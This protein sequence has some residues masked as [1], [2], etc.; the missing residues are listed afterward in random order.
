MNTQ[1]HFSIRFASLLINLF[2]APLNSSAVELVGYV[3]HYRLDSNYLNNILPNQL[4][5][6]DEVRYFGLSAGSNG[7]ITSLSGSIASHKNN[8]AAIKAIID[9]LPAADRPRLDITLGG[10]SQDATFTNVAA[11]S[12]LRTVLAE[13]IVSLLD[14]TGAMAVDIDWE[15]PNNGV[16]LDSSYPALLKRIKQEVGAER[17]VYATVAPSLVISNSIFTG[18]DAIDG[19]SLMTYDLGWW[20]NDPSDPNNGEHSLP[21]HTADALQAWTDSPGSTNQRPWVFG[22]WGNGS[23]SE[24]IGVGLPFYGRNLT[25]GSAFTYGQLESGGSTSDGN[26]YSYQGQTVWI[27]GPDLVEQRVQFADENN[28][29]NLIIWELA[30]DSNP[31]DP[32][33]LLRRAYEAKTALEDLPGDYDGDGSIDLDDYSVWSTTYGSTLDLRADGNADGI[34]DAA[35][36]TIWRDLNSVAVALSATSIPEPLSSSL[37]FLCLPFFVTA[38]TF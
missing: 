4:V 18:P 29:Q 27:P 38:R 28:L 23:P 3:P 35:D 2:I 20:S 34:V 22:K 32:N 37:L 11:S 9:G 1:K 15:H 10:A 30:Q 8:I 31:S 14:E 13:N 36:F 12:A 21:E 6:L 33:S 26:Y 16:E 25:N 7:E 19:V 24:K 5:M 17:R